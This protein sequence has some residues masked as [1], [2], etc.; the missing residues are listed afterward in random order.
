[1]F[2]WAS[3]DMFPCLQPGLLWFFLSPQVG[4][5]PVIVHLP[6]LYLMLFPGRT[7]YAHE[8]DALREVLLACHLL[9]NPCGLHTSPFVYPVT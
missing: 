8:P 7:L 6:H 1:L 5:F 2:V 4:L 3:V 9:V